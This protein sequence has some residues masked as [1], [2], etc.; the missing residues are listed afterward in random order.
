MATKKSK[1]STSSKKSTKPASAKQTKAEATKVKAEEV[2]DK[3]DNTEPDVVEEVVEVVEV[4]APVIDKTVDKNGKKKLTLSD[5]LAAL[6]P[7]ALIAELI[8]TFVITAVFIRLVNNSYYG[9]IGIALALAAMVIAFVG[10]SGAHFNPA[11]TL[12]QWI[13]RK[14]NGV[15]AVAYIVAQVLGA[16]LAFFIL[17]GINNAGYDYEATVRQGVESAGVTEEA[18]EQYGGYDQWVETY[19]GIDTI[20]AQLGIS[21]EAPELFQY[22]QLTE[23][24]E[25]VAL[26][27]EILGSIVVGVGAAYAYVKRKDNKVAAGLAMGVSLIAGLLIAGSTAIL[28][29]AIAAT[30]GVFGW[31]SVQAFMWPILV[32]IIGS[33]LGA[34]IGFAI[35]KMMSKNEA[36]NAKAIED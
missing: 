12:A 9:L 16:I 34:T 19:G 30:M 17:T 28:N 2:A 27:A 8:G 18:L 33:V 25:W 32:Y 6:N 3:I 22:N 29:P 1:R 31:G 26:L 4:E 23:G 36:E 11:I 10:I 20:A 7:A 13:N 14:I 24:K 21:K 15:K 5:K 35:Y